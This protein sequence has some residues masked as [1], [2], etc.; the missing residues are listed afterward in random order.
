M[1]RG[2]SCW[3]LKALV[4]HCRSWRNTGSATAKATKPSGRYGPR[5]RRVSLFNS[6][7]QHEWAAHGTCYSTLEP[8]CLP[9]GS[10]TGAEA[11]AFFEQVVALFQTLPTYSWLESQGITPSTTQTYTLSQ[12]NSALKTASGVRCP[13]S[14]ITRHCTN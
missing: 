10:P 14:P 4:P 11:V 2:F 8:S 9:S 5:I 7:S 3:S 13:A 12:L 1:W 6:A